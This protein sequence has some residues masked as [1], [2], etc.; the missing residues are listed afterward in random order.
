ESH[1]P[2]CTSA[3]STYAFPTAFAARDDRLSIVVTWRPATAETGAEH[4]RNV[5]PSTWTVQ[6]PHCAIPHPYLVPVRPSSSRMTHSSG[7]FGSPS[8]SR[9]VPLMLSVMA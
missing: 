6:A 8:K 1:H 2:H 4:E 3:R 7:V 5:C 9:R